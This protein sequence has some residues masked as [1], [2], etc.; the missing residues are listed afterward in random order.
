MNISI[1]YNSSKD[2]DGRILNDLTTAFD[3]KAK[4]KI[5]TE[6]ITSSDIELSDMVVAM[7]GDGTIIRALKASSNHSIPV[8]GINLGRIGFLAA[9][10]PNEVK[11]AAQH[12]L[13]GN[14]IIEERMMMEAIIESNGEKKV[15]DALNDVTVSR[16]RCHK[17]IDILLKADG[18]KL[19]EFRADGVIVSTPTGSTAYSLSAGGPI[20]DPVMEV[21]LVTPVCAYDLHTRSMVLMADN[22]LAISTKG[23]YPS[24]VEIDGAEV[25][26]IGTGDRISIR[27][28]EKK[29]RLVKLDEKSFLSVVR[30]KFSI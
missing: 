2:K 24:Y 10:E 27:R 5:F 21:F 13:S 15:V 19:D 23:K 22:T 18:E 12:I 28:S 7:G 29:G 6:K 20:V 17:M 14:Y 26:Q 8:C 3:G 1:V 25:A 16:G 30:K 11:K 9:F 4:L